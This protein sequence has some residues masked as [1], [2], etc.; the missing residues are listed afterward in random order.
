ME[1]RIL[2]PPSLAKPSGFNHGIVT[3]E[4]QLLFIAGQPGLDAEGRIAE[5][6]DLVSQ[7]SRAL[8]NL[9]TVALSAGASLTDIV[10]LT[11]Y[12]RDRDAYKE[13]LQALGT[14]WNSFFGR[15]YPTVTL[16]EVSSLFDD[17]ALVEMDAIAVIGRSGNLSA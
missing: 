10:K 12:V 1:K 7:F 5:P 4:G 2:N 3:E 6:G 9:Q 17:G 14:V 11:I 8:G 15:Y 16:V 13:N